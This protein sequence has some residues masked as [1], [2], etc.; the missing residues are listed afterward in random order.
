M[1]SITSLRFQIF[2]IISFLKK[3]K[4]SVLNVNLN[5][6]RNANDAKLGQNDSVLLVGQ[7][8]DLRKFDKN[9]LANSLAQLQIPEQVWMQ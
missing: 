1:L 8:K 4:G 9:V 5:Y 3:Q 2:Q 7:P 6:L